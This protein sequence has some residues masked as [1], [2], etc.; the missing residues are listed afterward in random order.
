VAGLSDELHSAN[1]TVFGASKAAAQLEG[2]KCFATTFMERHDIPLPRSQIVTSAADALVA[3]EQYGG[4]S[5]SVIKA[6]GLAGGKGVFLPDN[7]QEA[8][9]AIDK[10]INGQVDGDGTKC[11]IQARNHGPEVSVFVLSDG[12]DY[13]IIPLT[14]QDHKR[15]L[16]GDKGPNTGGMGHTRRYLAGWC[17]IINGRN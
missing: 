14:S 1:I 11:I 12:S 6:D 8:R 16:A 17:L 15:L 7:Q 5:N 9:D 2:S 13:R 4:A 3:I 10:I